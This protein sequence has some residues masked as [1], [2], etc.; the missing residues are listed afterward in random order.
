MAPV[1]VGVGGC[2]RVWVNVD[3]D[4]WVDGWQRGG[5]G[6]E[7]EWAGT[8]AEEGR[9]DRGKWGEQSECVHGAMMRGN[10]TTTTLFSTLAVFVLLSTVFTFQ[11]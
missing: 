9:G 3:A 1:G 11:E 10:N 2:G 7:G 8:M 4:V 6:K 5:G